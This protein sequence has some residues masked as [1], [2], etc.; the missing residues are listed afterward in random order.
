MVTRTLPPSA[1]AT[2]ACAPLSWHIFCTVIDNYGDIGVCWR[3]ARQIAHE[4]GATVRLWVDDLPSFARL[5]PALDITLVQQE[6]AGIDIRHWPRDWQPSAEIIPHQIVVEA[7]GCPLPE[8]WLARMAE[9]TPAPVWINLDYLSAED[10]VEGCHALPSRHPRLSL[11]Q[12]F[13]YPG[14]TERTGGLLHEHGLS[15]TRQA[16]QQALTNSDRNIALQPYFP[17]LNIV[18]NALLV[19]LFCYPNPALAGLLPRWEHSQQPI[20]LIVPT[21]IASAQFNEFCGQ[22]LTTGDCW[23]RG[24]LTISSVPFVPQEAYDRLLWSA[25]LAFVRGEDSFA[26]AQWAARPFVW[27]IYPQDEAAHLLKLD[28][29]L[30]RYGAALSPT[31]RAAQQAFW[32]AWNAGDAQATTAHWPALLAA[33][34]ALTE[35]AEHWATALSKLGNLADNLTVFCQQLRQTRTTG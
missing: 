17:G 28:A 7:F 30:A 32:H 3:L 19:P 12:H 25:D 6:V 11:T 29:F 24:A 8:S 13:Y 26:R 27:H 10:W 9:Q 1:P 16:W 20:H 15:T 31:A 23:Q 14:F 35:H 18:S 4:Q 5:C 33:L 2:K 22:P 34:P 21:G